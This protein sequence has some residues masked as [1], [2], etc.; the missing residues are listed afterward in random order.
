MDQSGPPVYVAPIRPSIALYGVADVNGHVS[1]DIKSQWGSIPRLSCKS[2]WMTVIAGGIAAVSYFF[3]L[4][5][6]VE[7]W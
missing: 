4:E 5:E 1:I 2:D 3:Q 7:E 6:A